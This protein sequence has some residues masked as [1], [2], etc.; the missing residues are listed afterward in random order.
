MPRRP[1]EKTR[2]ANRLA[3]NK[4]YNKNRPAR[5]KFYDTSQWRKLRAWLLRSHPLCA[6]CEREGRVIP[7][8]LVD[9]IVPI[10]DGGSR[11]EVSNLQVLCLACH[12]KKHGGRGA[13]KSGE[14]RSFSGRG[15]PIDPPQ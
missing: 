1:G 8:V 5:H 4:I 12:N 6:Q 3:Q 13:K 2:A 15:S 7:G 11:T 14:R 10:E 9:H